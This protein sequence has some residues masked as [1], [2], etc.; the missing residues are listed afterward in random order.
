MAAGTAGGA[1]LASRAVTSRIDRNLATASSRKAELK[2]RIQERAGRTISDADRQRA[3]D[4]A[5]RVSGNSNGP[6]AAL[7]RLQG[8]R[9]SR[10]RQNTSTTTATTPAA[11]PAPAR[12][13]RTR[14]AEAPRVIRDAGQ[15]NRLPNPV[16]VQMGLQPALPVDRAANLVAR[17]RASGNHAGNRHDASANR[18][19]TQISLSA[20]TG[21]QAPRIGLDA[22]RANRQARTQTGVAESR[23]GAAR[24]LMALRQAGPLGRSDAQAMRALGGA[25]VSQRGTR[26]NSAIVQMRIDA[27]QRF[28]SRGYRANDK[29][30]ASGMGTGRDLS[31]APAIRA[32]AARELAEV[33]RFR[34]ASFA[35]TGQRGPGN[36]WRTA[37]GAT[38]VANPLMRPN[39][40]AAGG[41]N[42]TMSISGQNRA[43]ATRA[44]AD[45]ANAG[46]RAQLAAQQA[47]AAPPP[48]PPPARAPRAPRRSSAPS[49][50]AGSQR[51]P[52][53]VYG[54][55][56][57]TPA[58]LT[59]ARR[60]AGTFG[61]Y[62]SQSQH[63]PA[64][65]SAAVGRAADLGVQLAGRTNDQKFNHLVSILG[66]PPEAARHIRVTVHG[67]AINLRNTHVNGGAHSRTINMDTDGTPYVYNDYYIP[68]D[69]A[70]LSGMATDHY[71]RQ[72]LAARAAGISK[73]RVSGAGRGLGSVDTTNQTSGYHMW[74]EYGF[75]GPVGSHGQGVFRRAHP[76]LA[77]VTSSSTFNETVHHPDPVVARAA[78]DAWRREG[79]GTHRITL[80]IGDVNSP[81]MKAYKNL[82]RTRRNEDWSQSNVSTNA[83]RDG[84]YGIY[85]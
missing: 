72:I 35:A 58:Q 8:V 25:D 20:R 56:N 22:Y 68:N 6:S 50:R 9:A 3:N 42:A 79:I 81:S 64:E 45:R 2:K 55:T 61:D 11:T 36:Y 44:Y 43:D 59:E 53:A 39:L 27:G 16:R 33:R 62:A 26:I 21:P 51:S 65:R 17:V 76:A 67:D 70:R 84:H 12:A 85:R 24:G 13:P 83:S 23:S 54:T 32:T 75:D 52:A 15:T 28:N 78:R 29:G 77:R 14:R 18:H 80:D 19:L 4:I 40:R 71:N 10:T 31:N 57:Y 38:Q 34:N 37:A 47:A 60:H 82:Y 30:Y 46:L 74:V 66:A 1:A 63:S 73:I 7:K 69:T 41:T 5:S 48:P 49:A